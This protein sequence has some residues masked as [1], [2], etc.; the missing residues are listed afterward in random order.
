[1]ENLITVLYH[2][3]EK[4]PYLSE[5]EHDGELDLLRLIE[6]DLGVSGVVPPATGP[7]NKPAAPVEVPVPGP[8]AAPDVVPG[9]EPPSSPEVAT[10]AHAFA[11][12]F[13]PAPK[14]GRH[15]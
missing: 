5:I 1:M 9:F 14:D 11:P 8:V 2:L 3:I 7:T 4:V 6:K 13:T 12:T 10:P 15:R